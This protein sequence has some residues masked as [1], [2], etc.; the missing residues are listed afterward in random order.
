MR[1]K[2][3][4]ETVGSSFTQ[5]ESCLQ[6]KGYSKIFLKFVSAFNLF[7]GLITMSLSFYEA[8]V[9][10]PNIRVHAPGDAGKVEFG[11]I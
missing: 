11:W 6:A 7:L 5:W 2:K 10:N 3:L 1:S 4:K 8:H 9:R